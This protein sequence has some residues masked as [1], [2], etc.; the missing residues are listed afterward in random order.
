M[1]QKLP[2]AHIKAG[3]IKAAH[4][5]SG[6]TESG[7]TESAKTLLVQ[8]IKSSRRG[9]FPAAIAQ[10][11]Q[12]LHLQSANQDIID[13]VITLKSYYYRGC[14]LSSLR[15]YE[16]AIADFSQVIHFSQH[17]TSTTP[18][19][20]PASKLTEL[21][22]HRG[23]AYR[24]LGHHHHAAADLEE[25]VVRSGGSAQSYACRGL[26]KLDIEDFAGAIADFT[27]ALQI[28]P[29]FAQC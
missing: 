13:P 21:Y 2:A 22:I 11:T 16:A 12:A 27:Q 14:A 26:L 24:Q 9:D 17:A 6:H 8:G 19:E 15:Q 7:H 10:L 4:T 25:G 29:T 23:N 3:H 1:A 18:A 5:E 28:H 20:V